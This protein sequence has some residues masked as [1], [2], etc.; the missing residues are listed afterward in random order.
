M[1]EWKCKSKQNIF[2]TSWSFDIVSNIRYWI[3]LTDIVQY[4]LQLLNIVEYWPILS[5]IVQYCSIDYFNSSLSCDIVK[6]I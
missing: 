2:E 3:M 6:N 1:E 5:N 4:H